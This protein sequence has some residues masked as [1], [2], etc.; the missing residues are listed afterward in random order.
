MRMLEK[1]PVFRVSVAQLSVMSKRTH[2]LSGFTM[3]NFVPC[4]AL[5]QLFAS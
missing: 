1:L 5:S 2:F 3:M 4:Q